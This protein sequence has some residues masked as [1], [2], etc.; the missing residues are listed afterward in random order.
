MTDRW[1][2]NDAFWTTAF[3]MV[4]SISK[5][6]N[7]WKRNECWSEF[8]MNIA[9][10]SLSWSIGWAALSFLGRCSFVRLFVPLWWHPTKSHFYLPQTLKPIHFLKA[11]DSS[12]SKMNKEHKY[13]DKDEYKDND[14]DKGAK[15][16]TE[17]LTVCYI[18]G[19]LTAQAFQ[20]WWWMPP[21]GHRPH[22]C[23]FLHR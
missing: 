16:I 11:Y 20:F 18:F 1:T 14:K 21:P 10:L 23:H 4:Y 17:S 13:K 9:H 3:T 19:I 6:S 2:L 8:T 15:R 5:T 7:L 12:Y 22:I